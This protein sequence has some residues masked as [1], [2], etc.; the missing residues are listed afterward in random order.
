MEPTTQT[1]LRGMVLALSHL[2]SLETTLLGIA[3]GGVSLNKE[4]GKA[5]F[6]GGHG[7]HTAGPSHAPVRKG[8]YRAGDCW[9]FFV[10]LPLPWDAGGVQGLS[11][12]CSRD[13]KGRWAAEGS[14][15]CVEGGLM[16][17]LDRAQDLR[18]RPGGCSVRGQDVLQWAWGRVWSQTSKMLEVLIAG[19]VCLKGPSTARRGEVCG[20][21]EGTSRVGLRYGYGLGVVLGSRWLC[22]QVSEV[23]SGWRLDRGHHSYTT[24][25]SHASR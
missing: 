19:A 6:L 10:G 23:W 16:T 3:K 4:N 5:A 11:R 24:H 1:D 21:A 9:G 2:Q 8:S 12:A 22:K 14:L 20:R 15:T 7:A 17:M 25:D 13:G 18:G